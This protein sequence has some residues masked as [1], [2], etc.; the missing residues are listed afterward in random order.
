MKLPK[1]LQYHR[2]AFAYC[3]LISK[4]DIL[5]WSQAFCAGKS[6]SPRSSHAAVILGDT[7]LVIG[8]QAKGEVFS[9]AYVL[10]LVTLTWR[11][12]SISS[13]QCCGRADPCKVRV[14]FSTAVDQYRSVIRLLARSF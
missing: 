7:L 6:P 8:G 2:D 11:Q 5:R 10:C 3:C 14:G 1:L 12:V 13:R 9:D 4:F